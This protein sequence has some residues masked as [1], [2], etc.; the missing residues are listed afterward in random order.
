MAQQGGAPD[1]PAGGTS[2][3]CSPRSSLSLRVNQASSSH[4]DSWRFSTRDCGCDTSTALVHLRVM[5][6]RYL[7]HTFVTW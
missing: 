4:P 7:A 3:R 1:R 5:T 6:F 2:I